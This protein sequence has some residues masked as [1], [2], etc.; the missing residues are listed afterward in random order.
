MPS[1]V[2]RLTRSERIGS[3]LLL[4]VMTLAVV[5]FAMSKGLFSS[6]PVQ[7][8]VVI[9]YSDSASAVPR[10]EAVKLEKMRNKSKKASGRKGRKD[11]D[12]SAGNRQKGRKG[13]GRDILD[14]EPISK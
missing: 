8:P 6:T 9:E 5:A 12:P 14:E 2:N 11:Y 3:L 13:H 10:R 7:E 1:P 4:I